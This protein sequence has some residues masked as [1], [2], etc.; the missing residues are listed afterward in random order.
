M[1]FSNDWGLGVSM[2]D[3]HT[4]YINAVLSSSGFGGIGIAKATPASSNVFVTQDMQS[5]T[6]T[7]R[8][9]NTAGFTDNT[10]SFKFSH[11][12]P[13][14][15]TYHEKLHP[16]T[17]CNPFTEFDPVTINV[18]GPFRVTSFDKTGGNSQTTNKMFLTEQI[19]IENGAV[20]FFETA[21]PN[22]VYVASILWRSTQTAAL[23]GRSIVLPRT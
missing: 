20:W 14:G 8:T 5:V 4:D 19:S 12:I 9:T 15:K 10:H 3:A 23:T 13:W 11:A 21:R 2:P 17:I 16:A 18:A 6:Y 22:S 1:G 7:V